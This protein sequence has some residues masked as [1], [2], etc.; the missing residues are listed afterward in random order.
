MES[1]LYKT[2]VQWSETYSGGSTVEGKKKN[3]KKK[4][5]NGNIK[6][7]FTEKNWKL[8]NPN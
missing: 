1:H 3:Y 6:E 8:E 7:R 4:G 5:D 2:W